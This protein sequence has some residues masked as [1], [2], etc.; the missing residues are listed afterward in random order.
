MSDDIGQ[1]MQK[2]TDQLKQGA[3][4]GAS[5]LLKFGL[6]TQNAVPHGIDE[7]TLSA[8]AFDKYMRDNPN[9]SL[10]EL[11]NVHDYFLKYP[12]VR[13]AL[14]MTHPEFP[15]AALP[16]GTAQAGPQMMLGN[17]I[18]TLMLNGLIQENSPLTQYLTGK[19]TKEQLG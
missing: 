14:A 8:M 2:Y 1:Y 19:P 3:A 9:A 11:A 4:Q 7:T 15:G 17:M 6:L 12:G 10:E 18:S 5:D 16:A 13:N